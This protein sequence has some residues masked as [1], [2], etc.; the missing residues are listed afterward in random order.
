MFAINK[1]E[2]LDKLEELAFLKKKVQEFRLQVNEPVTKSNKNVSEEVVKTMT[3]KSIKNNKAKEN[4]NNRLV[5]IM[6]YRVLKASYL[7][8]P[9]SKIT[10]PENTGQFKLVKDSD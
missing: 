9:S 7:L 10:H 6:N 3:E 4:F 1:R 8:S 5:E 2:D